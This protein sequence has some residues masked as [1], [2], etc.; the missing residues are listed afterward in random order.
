MTGEVISDHY[1]PVQF[2]IV[3]S[4]SEDSTKIILG[5][6]HEST[7][8]GFFL[9]FSVETMTLT[10]AEEIIGPLANFVSSKMISNTDFIGVATFDL[11]IFDLFRYSIGASSPVIW[12]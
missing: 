2:A 5:G 9:V 4:I 3:L 11:F 7:L 1:S 12:H 10:V 6:I 8:N